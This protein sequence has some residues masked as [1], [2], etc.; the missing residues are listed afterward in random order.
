MSIATL[1]GSVDG[2]KIGV[3][4]KQLGISIRT[5]HMYERAGLMI[6]QKN[7]AG[8]RYFTERDVEWLTEIRRLIK[9]GI[10]IA[11]IRHLLSLVP[12][13]EI[14]SCAFRGKAACPVIEDHGLPCWANKG[15]RCNATVQECRLCEVH[16][17][18]FSVGQLKRRLSIRLKDEARVE[19]PPPV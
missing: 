5:I 2:V 19:S 6:S 14:K 8:T 16:E 17:I 3:V 4:A 10:G 12:C 9:S 15:N 11:G 7:P 13:W 1:E 18:R